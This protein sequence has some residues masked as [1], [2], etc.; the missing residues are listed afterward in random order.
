MWHNNRYYGNY[1]NGRK[2]KHLNTLEKYHIYE[3]S[4]KNLHTNDTNIDTYNP[5]FEELYN[6]I[7]FP[8]LPT[9]HNH[10]V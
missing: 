10:S 9:P 4:K 8:P 7:T 2:G 6:T 5:I 3:V 1:S